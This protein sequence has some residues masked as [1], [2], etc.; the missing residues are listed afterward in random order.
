[1]LPATKRYR[2]LSGKMIISLISVLD[3]GEEVLITWGQKSDD[4]TSRIG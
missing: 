4:E 2:Y 3:V 1:M